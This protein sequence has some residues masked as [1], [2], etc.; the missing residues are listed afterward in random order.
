VLELR[1]VD[2]P[3]GA[4]AAL[5][6]AR[7]LLA[8]LGDGADRGDPGAAA[9][10]ERW[11]FAVRPESGPEGLRRLLGDPDPDVR[12]AAFRHLQRRS[13]LTGEER[14]RARGDPD[15]PLRLAALAGGARG[16]KPPVE[17]LLAAARDPDPW[18]AAGGW[19]AVKD[20]FAGSGIPFEE[21]AAALRRPEAPVRF[22]ASGVLGTF[23]PGDADLLPLLRIALAD[24]DPGVRSQGAVPLLH[25]P[26]ATPGLGAVFAGLL[27]GPDEDLRRDALIQ[28]SIRD[29]VAGTAEALLPFL[30]VEEDAD[31][32]VEALGKQGAEARAAIPR[33]R[34]MAEEAG[35]TEGTR[36]RLGALAALAGIEGRKSE[37]L[38]HIR[39]L[40][41]TGTE[42]EA[43]V[44][45][46]FLDDLGA[47]A[48]MVPELTAR[49]RSGS[50]LHRI[51]V[52]AA[53]ER[54]G[55]AAEP[56]LGEIET[57]CGS[58]DP[59]LRARARKAG[60]AIRKWN[61]EFRGE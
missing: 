51:A 60:E 9:W 19:N 38:S 30:D 50:A 29:G 24:G 47:S 4:Q 12:L 58:E 14:E 61:R 13:A 48:D 55:I 40:L 33:L 26:R 59:V 25:L 36:R 7:C 34:R 54:A 57:L 21:I 35:G 22:A 39:R 18:V 2:D 5:R 8:C 17:D 1:L 42:E 28:L 27:T 52:L 53:L 6:L 32:A 23:D 44:A 45:L 15:P 41:A 11:R 3:G 49:L 56:A 16:E 43:Q 10:E 31:L 37:V 46:H 20:H